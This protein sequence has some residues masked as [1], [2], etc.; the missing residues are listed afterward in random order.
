MSLSQVF[1][2]FY[3]PCYYC[4]FIH[5]TV[6]FFKLFSSYNFIYPSCY[7]LPKPIFMS[8]SWSVRHCTSSVLRHISPDKT[9]NNHLCPHCNRK[10]HC[11]LSAVLSKSHPYSPIVLMELFFFSLGWKPPKKRE[12]SEKVDANRCGLFV[13]IKLHLKWFRVGWSEVFC[14]SPCRESFAV[15][16]G[17]VHLLEEGDKE[18]VE[19]ETPLSCSAKE[20]DRASEARSR[21]LHAMVEQLRPE[22]TMKLVNFLCLQSG[23]AKLETYHAERI[24]FVCLVS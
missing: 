14:L 1:F 20:G 4:C 6:L 10:K 16:K 5:H 8:V 2:P 15:V 12:T 24:L 19:E 11:T 17:A 9:L 23:S 18:D 13:V 3:R 21:Q 22:D 7:L